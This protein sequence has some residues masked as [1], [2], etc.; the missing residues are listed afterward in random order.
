MKASQTAAEI[1]GCF[2]ERMLLRSGTFLFIHLRLYQ[3]ATRSPEALHSV[4]EP[5][6]GHRYDIRALV[7]RPESSFRVSFPGSRFCRDAPVL[8]REPLLN[9][10]RRGVSG[11]GDRV[12]VQPCGESGGTPD[13]ETPPATVPTE[14][15]WPEDWGVSTNRLLDA[16]HQTG[17][18]LRP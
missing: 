17:R 12:A 6:I 13:P 7:L 1:P 9:P 8:Y 4:R 16:N 15:F 3:S 10:S 18:P 11:A 14:R 2:G 5:R